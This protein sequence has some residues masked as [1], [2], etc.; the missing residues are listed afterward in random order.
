MYL[1]CEIHKIWGHQMSADG[2]AP[3]EEKVSAVRNYPWPSTVKELQQF[4]GMLNFYHRFLTHAAAIL[5]PLHAALASRKYWTITGIYC[6]TMDIR[7][8][9]RISRT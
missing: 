5:V 1:W 2:I 7:N 8:G 9:I 6:T 4:W 3:L